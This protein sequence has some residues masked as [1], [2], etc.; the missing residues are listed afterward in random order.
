MNAL[1]TCVHASGSGFHGPVQALIGVYVLCT[2]VCARLD[3]APRACTDPFRCLRPVHVCVRVRTWLHVPVPAF[4]RVN[5]L[6]TWVH[7]S[8]SGFHGPVQAHIGVY[9]LCTCVCARLDVAPR[10]CTGNFRCVLP[11]HVCVCVWTL[12][13]VPMPALSGV[14][15]LCTYAYASERR[16][17]CMYRPLSVGT[18]CARVTTRR[19]VAQRAGTGTFPCVR[20]VHV[21][22][23]RDVAPY[24]CT[25]PFPYVRPVH[26]DTPVLTW[27][28]VSI[29]ALFHVNALCV[30]VWT[31]HLPA[32]FGV[33]PLCRCVYACV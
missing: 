30:R 25:G 20:P 12:L 33:Y 28:Y 9:A 11:V 2:C 5:A 21:C 31:W 32:L 8:G 23:S 22:T 3:V 15:A 6:C 29:P 27:L 24:T 10:A 17:M 1:C 26:V 4:F 7:A 14:Y 18:P 13:H 19:H 16:S